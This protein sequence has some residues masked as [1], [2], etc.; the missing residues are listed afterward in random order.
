MQK[1]IIIV[2]VLF[3]TFS[4]GTTFKGSSGDD[5]KPGE[6]GKPGTSTNNKGEDGKDGE[7]GNSKNEII[8]IKAQFV[9]PDFFRDFFCSILK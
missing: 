2:V 3:T 8:G 7:N 1:L 4:C 9:N 5:G 6:D